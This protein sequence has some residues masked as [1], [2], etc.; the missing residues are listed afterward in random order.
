M[1]TSESPFF[2]FWCVC[3]FLLCV[4]DEYLLGC[5]NNVT[6]EQWNQINRLWLS[7]LWLTQY[8]HTQSNLMNPL[9]ISYFQLD[10]QTSKITNSTCFYAH[11]RLK[12]CNWLIWFCMSWMGFWRMQLTCRM[13]NT[14]TTEPANTCATFHWATLCIWFD[15]HFSS[16]PSNVSQNNPINLN[17]A[18]W[19]QAYTMIFS[20]AVF[21]NI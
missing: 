3:F 2:G 16:S 6:K 13:H 14:W 18:Q 7:L 10:S 8:I 9:F 5:V 21:N 17:K 20:F 11:Y 4:C 1:C 15:A 19:S 12:W